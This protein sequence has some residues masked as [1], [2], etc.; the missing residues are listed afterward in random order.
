M[1]ATKTWYANI[2]IAGDHTI[3]L[4]TCRRFVN[5]DK[6]CVTVTKTDFVYTGGMQSGVCVRMI[7]YPRFPTPVSDLEKQAMRLAVTLNAALH[8][9]SYSV[10][11]PDRTIWHSEATK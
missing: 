4:D 3:A 11:F 1:K 5:F 6:T 9:E 7:Q 8:Q 2:W 10:E